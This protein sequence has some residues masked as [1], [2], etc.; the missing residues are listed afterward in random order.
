[1]AAKNTNSDRRG[2]SFTNNKQGG[3]FDRLSTNGIDSHL[4]PLILSLSND[5]G[6]VDVTDAHHDVLVG[7][8]R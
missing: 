2:Q 6:M 7:N 8:A 5:E 4:H 3:C 1:M